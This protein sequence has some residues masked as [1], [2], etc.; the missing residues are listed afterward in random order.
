MNRSSSMNLLSHSNPQVRMYLEGTR[1]YKYRI[2]FP[3]LPAR[4]AVE[5][6]DR[7]EIEAIIPASNDPKAANRKFDLSKYPVVTIDTRVMTVNVKTTLTDYGFKAEEINIETRLENGRVGQS[8]LSQ[9]KPEVL[10]SFNLKIVFTLNP[11]SNHFLAGRRLQFRIRDMLRG[12]SDWYTIKQ[13]FVR[14]PEI[15]SVSCLN[16]KCKIRGKGL[17]YIGQISTDSGK[18]WKPPPQIQPI[19]NGKSFM[20]ISAVKDKK[21]IRIKLRDF[22]NTDGLGLFK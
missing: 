5:A 12:D 20:S 9:A 11:Q 3:V 21:F 19:E 4:P 8:G 10:D 2:L 7:R 6:N 22:P 17:D 1:I 16:G 13:T 14:T 18:T 15:K